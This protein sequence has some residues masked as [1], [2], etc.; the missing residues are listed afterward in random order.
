MRSPL[1]RELKM[2]IPW[3]GLKLN[4]QEENFLPFYREAIIPV[5]SPND[6]QFL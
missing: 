4:S 1:L 6:Q 2:S 5:G 3:F